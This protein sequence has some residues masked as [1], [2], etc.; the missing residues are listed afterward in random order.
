MD[1]VRGAGKTREAQ[2]PG[3]AREVAV[4]EAAAIF[5]ALGHEGRL[6]ILCH[7]AGGE[8]SVS[9]LENLI[10]ARQ[11]VVSQHLARLRAD[12]LVQF[13]RDGQTIYYSIRDARVADLLQAFVIGKGAAAGR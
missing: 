3:L 13:R 1:L 9:Q 11:S 4:A 12:Q 8:C 10:D 5:K 7:L 2:A 6:R